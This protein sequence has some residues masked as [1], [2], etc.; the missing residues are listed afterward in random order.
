MMEKLIPKLRF[1]EFKDKWVLK[2]LDEISEISSG[3]T[4]SRSNDNFWNGNVP[5]VSTT[6]IDFN[7]IHSTDEYITELGLKN[8]SA[9][10]YPKGTI[11]IAMYG[12]GKTRG[13][14]AVLGIDASTNQACGAIMANSEIIVNSF[15]FQ[16]LAKRYQE[17]RDLSNQGGQENL[18]GSIIKGLPVIFPSLP[19]Q[20]KIASFLS[21]VD[22][23]LNLLKEKK[24]ALETY[25]KGMMQKIFSQELRFKDDDGNDFEDWEEK[26]LGECL[27]YEQPT[28]YLVKS[29]E[30]SDSYDTPVLTAG[31]TFILGY[32]NEEFGIYENYPAIIFDDFTTAS[33]Y[34]NF[35][36][37]AKSSAM[38]ILKTKGND[39]IKF[40][41][42]AMQMLDFEVGGHG[43]HWI[44]VF[45]V[46]EIQMPCSNEQTKI[47][48]FLSAI[49]E[50][51]TLVSTQIEEMQ[52]YK[53][54]LLQGMF[55]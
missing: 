29:T 40:L 7:F 3:G 41:Y 52:A 43:R 55:C 23:K 32:T 30:Y 34:V 22:E 2:T 48:N 15:L 21:S 26:S 54:G 6:L 38:K 33:K 8:S 37:K 47:A 53:K 36:F 11:L 19:E 45:S 42:E 14:V 39:N 18:S 27:S 5:W 17:I 1:P 16:N 20:T 10:I 12:Q 25:K 46:M 31:K 44:S 4:P 51:I 9:K 50:K 28:Q 13:K 24:E 35:R 49:D